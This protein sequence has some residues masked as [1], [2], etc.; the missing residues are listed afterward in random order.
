[1]IVGSTIY[2]KEMS[3]YVSSTV[4]LRYMCILTLTYEFELP[5]QQRHVFTVGNPEVIVRIVCLRDTVG[6]IGSAN[7]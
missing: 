2:M 1:M 4:V 5:L 3:I 7:G 6:G